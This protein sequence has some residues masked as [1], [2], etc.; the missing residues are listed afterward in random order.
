MKA[1]TTHKNAAIVT[2]HDAAKMTKRRRHQIAMW[3]RDHADSL[4]AEGQLCSG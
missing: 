3:L 2:I 4:E 1:K